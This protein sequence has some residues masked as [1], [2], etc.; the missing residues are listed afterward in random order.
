M[1][2][3]VGGRSARCPAELPKR[4]WGIEVVPPTLDP[5]TRSNP[6]T[7]RT[8]CSLA[9]AGLL[10]VPISGSPISAQAA[11]ESQRFISVL[12]RENPETYEVVVRL[13]RAHGV[14]FG[15]LAEEGRTVRASDNKLPTYQFE[16]DILSRLIRTVQA[17]GTADD[18]AAQAAAGF[19]ALGPKAAAII[20]QANSFH[21]EVLGILSDPTIAQFP[22]RRAALQKAV[23][24]YRSR[25]DVALPIAPKDMQILYDHAQA[26]EFRT[27]YPDAD[28]MIWAGHWLKLAA[29]EPLTDHVGTA[30]TAGLDTVRVRYYA[31]LSFGEPPEHF[32]SELPLAPAIAPGLIFMSPESA[33]ILDNV[34]M[35]QEVLADIL[36]APDVM[37]VQGAIDAAVAFFMDPTL[38]MTVRGEWE[39]MALRHGIFFQG[40]YPLA[41]MTQS[42]RNQGGHA[43]HLQGGGPIMIPG[44]PG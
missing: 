39:I 15:A 14:L 7:Y 10:L 20:A 19:A 9:L 24:R 6:M 23:E 13:E 27:A 1:G 37:D 28:G 8:A 29:T 42:E 5:P 44:M 11:N 31:K 38:G 12:Q 26:L 41:V 16:N 34:N 30:R 43:V 21:R 18:V 25:P 3:G 33:I 40:G 35:L 2:A 4:F 22:A 36:V 17:E 32:P